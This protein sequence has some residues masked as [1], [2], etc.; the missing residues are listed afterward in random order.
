LPAGFNDI[1]DQVAAE[2]TLVAIPDAGQFVQRDAE[3]AVIA[4]ILGW[5]A[6]YP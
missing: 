1:R 5:L 3:D 2:L 6:K 4:T